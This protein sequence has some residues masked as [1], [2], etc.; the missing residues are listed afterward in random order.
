MKCIGTGSLGSPLH[1]QIDE[2][3]KWNR[4]HEM[5]VV[6]VRVNEHYGDDL[7]PLEFPDG[8]NLDVTEMACK[9]ASPMT[10]EEIRSALD[11]TVGSASITEQAKGKKGR[12]VVTC[13]DLSRPTPAGKFSPSSLSSSTRP[14][15]PITRSSSSAP[16]ASTTP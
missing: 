12:I 9:G 8:W 2:G 6:K 7:M 3:T 1:L 11:N 13:D 4:E 14:G 16:S 5:Q 15:S 10:D